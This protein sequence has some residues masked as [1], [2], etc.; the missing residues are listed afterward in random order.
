MQTLRQ[1]MPHR[2]LPQEDRLPQC[3]AVDQVPTFVN[4]WGGD[5]AAEWDDIFSI[6]TDDKDYTKDLI[7]KPERAE[8]NSR[9]KL[10][11]AAGTLAGLVRRWES[12]P[13]LLP[14]L[15]PNSP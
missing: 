8:Y 13:R 10:Y 14:K 3:G 12:L 1:Q 2:E 11:S 6:C 5:L 15:R 7:K 4:L 9:P